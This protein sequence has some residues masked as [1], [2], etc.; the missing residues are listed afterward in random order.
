MMDGQELAD[1]GFATASTAACDMVAARR[2][3]AGDVERPECAL[4]GI[5]MHESGNA[6]LPVPGAP[7][8]RA[9]DFQAF[10]CIS[11]AGNIA[12]GG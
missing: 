10:S 8:Q 4:R 5:R 11:C 7:H 3:G 2:T 6:P 9:E 1:N 12:T